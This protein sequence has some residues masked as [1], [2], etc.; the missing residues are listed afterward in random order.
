MLVLA[1]VGR[2]TVLCSH[3]ASIANS[4]LG[5]AHSS[6][7]NTDGCRPSVAHAPSQQAAQ[8]AHRLLPGD[9]HVAVLHPPPGVHNAGQA[10]A[11]VGLQTVEL[12]KRGR[13]PIGWQR[14][15]GEM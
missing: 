6:P 14:N 8:S 1:G 9:Q 12:L 3:L 4:T 11:S 15:E 13:G 2:R 5:P 7:E 10:A